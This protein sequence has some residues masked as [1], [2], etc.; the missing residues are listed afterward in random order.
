MSKRRQIRKIGRGPVAKRLGLKKGDMVSVKTVGSKPTVKLVGS[1]AKR[2]I[3]ASRNV[4]VTVSRPV[5]RQF[6]RTRRVRF[7]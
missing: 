4:R 2:R 3:M 6:G 1:G 5:G 7:T